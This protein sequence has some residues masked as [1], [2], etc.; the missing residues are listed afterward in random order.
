MD[1]SFTVD[2]YL[3]MEVGDHKLDLD[4]NSNLVINI[5]IPKNLYNYLWFSGFF[6]LYI[7]KYW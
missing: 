4:V 5:N 7:S 3:F 6:L 2:M 1:P